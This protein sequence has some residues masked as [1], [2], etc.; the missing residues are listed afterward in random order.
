ML[1]GQRALLAI[2]LLL[3]LLE[4]IELDTASARVG[5]EGLQACEQLGG[6]AIPTFGPGVERLQPRHGDVPRTQGRMVAALRANLDRLRQP[7]CPG[8]VPALRWA[9]A[10]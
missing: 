2:D 8:F 5:E 4:D 10:A 1:G 9:R 7:L 6:L 3:D